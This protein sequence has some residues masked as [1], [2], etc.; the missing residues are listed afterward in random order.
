MNVVFPDGNI[1]ARTAGEIRRQRLMRVAI[2]ASAVALAVIT[3][4]PGVAS[5]LNNREFLKVT[6]DQA[7]A[8][9]AV[10]WETKDKVGP[11]LDKLDP[12]LARLKEIDKYKKDGVPLFKQWGMYQG[13]VLEGPAVGVYVKAMQ[14]AMVKPVKGRLEDKIKLIKGDKYLHDRTLLK[15]YLMLSDPEHL[16]VDADQDL[17]DPEVAKNDGTE[18]TALTAAWYEILKQY[19]EVTEIELKKRLRPHVRYYLKLIKTKRVTPL[20][21]NEKLVQGAQ[22]TLQSVPVAKRY[23]DLFVNSLIDEKYVEG[24]DDVR[25]NKK[26]PPINLA[27]LFV[28]KPDALKLITSKTFQKE[29]RYKE[30]E[31]PYTEKGHYRVIRNIQ[32]GATYLE[33]EAWVVPLGPE[34]KLDRVPINLEHL[35]NEYDQQYASAWQDWL[36]D[37]SVAQPATVKEAIDLYG[38][39][40]SPP[41]PYVNILRAL[42]D[43]TQW[44]ASKKEVYENAELQRVMKDQARMKLSAMTGGLR[45]E[46][47]LQK[48]GPRTSTVPGIFRKTVD[49][50]V[51]SAAN[52]NDPPVNKYLSRL[53]ALRGVLQKEED[54]R[55]GV[56]PRLVQDRLT[57]ALKEA[58]DLL[59]G[60]D[61]RAKTI[62][63]PLIINPL[64]FA[65]TKLPPAGAPKPAVVAPGGRWRRY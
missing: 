60:S 9:D 16:D 13:D 49:F 37:I 52:G 63:T 20:P 47:D 12:L 38:V 14:N 35:A 4:W 57:D 6:L 33:R 44:K 1:A 26:Y 7:K 39:L 24:G 27:D 45:V 42:E 58:T 5:F 11:K 40:T 25:S 10:D 61:D 28:D 30:V 55:P 59:Q 64:N 15:T 18:V 29:K 65:S 3:A 53:E 31:G 41:R 50:A 36:L 8:A 22:K 32:E 2:S 21:P 56:D 54:A 34:E 51:P 19:S 46:V 48:I 62:L 23:Y 17:D 43:G